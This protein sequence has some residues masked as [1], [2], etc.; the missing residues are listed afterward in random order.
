MNVIIHDLYRYTLLYLRMK[1]LREESREV[2]VTMIRACQ[3]ITCKTG[4]LLHI[5][6]SYKY[7]T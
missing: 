7:I 3:S 1:W 6:F 5:W 2:G 4:D